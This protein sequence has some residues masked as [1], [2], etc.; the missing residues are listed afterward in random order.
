MYADFVGMGKILEVAKDN[1][2]ER[3]VIHIFKYLL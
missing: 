1:V 2:G 3:Y